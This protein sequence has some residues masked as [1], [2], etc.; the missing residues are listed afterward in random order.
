[1]K[2]RLV[3]INKEAEK[4]MVSEREERI[5]QPKKLTDIIFLQEMHS[6]RIY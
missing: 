4:Q 6:Q 5:Q 3:V 1:M 2:T